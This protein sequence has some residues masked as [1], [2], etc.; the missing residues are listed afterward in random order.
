MVSGFILMGKPLQAYPPSWVAGYVG[1]PFVDRG[2]TRDGVDCWGLVRLVYA[3]QF[4]ILL[5]DLSDEYSA[6]E[7]PQAASSVIFEKTTPGGLWRPVGN[8]KPSLGSVGVFSI[9]GLPAHVGIAVS[10]GLFLHAA[11]G[12]NSV[13]ESWRSPIWRPRLTGWYDYGGPV[14]LSTRRSI[15]QAYPERLHLPEGGSVEDMI[16]AGGIDPNSPGLRAYVG[17]EEIRRNDWAHARPSAGQHVKVV[18][19]PEGG[20]KDF[21]RVLL[22]ISVI[23]A[24]IY[25]GP[26]LAT[27]LGYT[28]TGSAA[29]I[30]TATLS[31]VGTLAVNSLVPPPRPNLSI[32]GSGLSSVSPTITGARNSA[33]PYAPVPVVFGEHRV[34]P[35][36]GALPYTE[37][38]GDDQYLRLLFII[39]YGPLSISDL[40]IGETPI[41]EFEGVEY[42]IREGVPGEAPITI[43][44]GVVIEES[45]SL[46]L[47]YSAGWQ[48]RTSAQDAD[49]LSVDITF[50]QGLARL[51]GGNPTE[52]SVAL[53][54]EYA[55]AGTGNWRPVDSGSRPTNARGLDYFFRT[56]ESRLLSNGIRYFPTSGGLVFTRPI[57][58]SA[59]GVFEREPPPEIEAHRANNPLLSWEARG[60]IYIPR[61]GEYRFSVDSANAADFS[62]NG[63]IVCSNYGGTTRTGPP[64]F[65]VEGRTSDIIRV[66]AGFYPFVFRVQGENDNIAA[67]LGWAGPDINGFQTVPGYRLYWRAHLSSESRGYKYRVFANTSG[68]G[69]HVFRG[70]RLGLIRRSISW[71][72]DPTAQYDV[73]IRRTTPDA[74]SE[75]VIDEFYWTVLRTIRHRDPVLLPNLARVAMRIKATDQLNGIVD[76]FSVMARSRIPDYDETTGEWEVRE[77]SNPASIFRAILQGPACKKPVSDSRLALRTLEEWHTANRNAGFEANIVFDYD[78]TLYERLQLI[79]SLGR[80]S[81]GMEDGLFSVVRDRR[82]EVPIQHFT[83]RNSSAFRGRRSFPDSPHA[84]RV[85]FLNAEKGYQQDERVV[86]ADGYNATNAERFETI[87]LFGVT[88]PE[89]AWRHGRYY[90]AVG[91]HRPET[92]E[93]SVDFEHLACRRGDLVLVTHD[94]PIIGVGFGRVRQVV[95][96]TAGLPAIIEIDT[97]VL[98]EEG[99]SYAIR[100]RKSD[101]TFVYRDI[102]T[103]PGEQTILRFESPIPANQPA[104]EP[105]DLFG[106]GIRGTESREMIVRSITMGPDLSATLALVDH[107]PEIHEA[108]RGPIPPHDSSIAGPQDNKGEVEPPVLDNTNSGDSIAIEVEGGSAPRVVAHL[109]RTS[110]I[111]AREPMMI[112]GRYRPI[113]DTSGRYRYTPLMP[114]AARA[115]IFDGLSSATSYEF[116][117]R[118]ISAAGDPSA[119]TSFFCD[120]PEI[121][122]A[123]IGPTG[124]TGP[125]GPQGP[126]G[127]TGPTGPAGA[128]GPT[129]PAGPTGPTGPTQLSTQAIWGELL[130]VP[131]AT[132]R[133]AAGLSNPTPSVTPTSADDNRGY[134][135]QYQTAATSGS[136]ASH[137]DSSPTMRINHSGSR[138]GIHLLTGSDIT[139][140]RLHAALTSAATTGTTQPTTVHYAGFCYGTDVHGTEH[141]RVWTANGS[142]GTAFNTGVTVAADTAYLFEIE[143]NNTDV[144][145][146]I[147]GSLVHTATA[148][149]PGSGQSLFWYYSVTTLTAAARVLKWGGTVV[150][151]P[152]SPLTS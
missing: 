37:I 111:S 44:P 3:E 38:V 8:D 80:A 10:D 12:A 68:G 149:L 131:G 20:G 144:K 99:K 107:A 98:M 127:P 73:R 26:Q 31:L 145:F 106:F 17:D 137:I 45:F 150:R 19:V 56:P 74:T 126:P 96:D 133:L 85:R 78:G 86:Y 110:G 136:A 62:F 143:V 114:A 36:Y 135:H 35:A 16:R 100:F 105:G 28:A 30:A 69:A 15:F 116:G 59:N 129:G 46:L 92:F 82:H 76:T 67:A 93:L 55:V 49:E 128:T 112:Q 87:E 22:T 24:S 11:R 83:P 40:K 71:P 57:N 97:P 39:G 104:P 79:A 146:Y 139:N 4:G 13:I 27:A 77:T 94:V 29:A 66:S 103:E 91:K 54:I 101:G 81:F 147:N 65:G 5:P 61:S 23:V 102:I 1:I 113:S 118:Y 89:L 7:D 125:A 142:S 41:D 52:T 58:W 2:R 84:L 130:P 18:V 108:D 121:E 123:S 63:R 70:S 50:P 51:S 53:E 151:R 25:L 14:V 148:T 120:T 33:R 34:V 9:R 72:V 122:S 60:Y 88:S 42:Q 124:P 48:T 132:A 47:S 115:A 43:Y 134:W 117:V 138:V 21:A 32:A 109:A 119:W 95:N 140:I 75:E 64:E 141:W 6:S 90:L 152:C